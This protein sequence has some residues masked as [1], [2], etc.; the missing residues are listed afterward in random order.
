M[1]KLVDISKTYNLGT[2]TQLNALKNVSFE[3][4]NGESVAIMGPSGCGKSTLLQILGC[5]SNH[6][7]G[8]YFINDEDASKISERE[9]AMLRNK[10]FGFVMQNFALIE[11]RNVLEN[12]KIPL[13]FDSGSSEK[14][15]IQKCK[16]ALERVGLSGYERKKTGLLSGGEKQR[17]AIA[18]AIV[19]DPEV[20]LA[21][22]PTG[23][24]DSK[25]RD[26]V[27]SLFGDINKSGTTLIVV[28]HDNTLKPYFSRI[29]ELNY[30]MITS[31][32]RR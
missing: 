29:I 1:L 14:D 3:I 27:I 5:I 2:S 16:A 6:D 22:E 15:R 7:S 26:C 20:L 11:Y 4:A 17:V 24:L 18:R 10:K 13:S 32:I 12:V 25:S 30:G 28:T 9:T 19:N 23:A 21:D 8:Q 31:D